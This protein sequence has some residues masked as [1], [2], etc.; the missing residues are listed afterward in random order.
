MRV[1]LFMGVCI[2]IRLFIFVAFDGHCLCSSAVQYFHVFVTTF[3]SLFVI[4]SSRRLLSRALSFVS[5]TFAF[6]CRYVCCT[7][8]YR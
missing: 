5:F 6:V 3:V 7:S 1:F 8:H 4:D 2:S